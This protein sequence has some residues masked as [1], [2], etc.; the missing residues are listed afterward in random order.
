MADRFV[1]FL[2]PDHLYRLFVTPKVAR[3]RHQY[4]ELER[5]RNV[6]TGQKLYN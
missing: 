1:R 2:E 6:G 5:F 4:R 3:D